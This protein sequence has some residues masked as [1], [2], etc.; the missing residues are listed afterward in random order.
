MVCW[1]VA[2]VFRIFYTNRYDAE[3][4][5]PHWLFLLRLILMYPFNPHD[6]P[7]L[8]ENSD[9]DLLHY[10]AQLLYPFQFGIFMSIPWN[11]RIMYLNVRYII[12]SIKQ[13]FID[14]ANI[15]EKIPPKLKKQKEFYKPNFLWS[16]VH[17]TRL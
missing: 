15:W 13:L 8:K 1:K 16:V 9:Y 7:Q 17:L 3:L 10:C 14:E 6:V 5:M 12:H 11:C 2:K 4:A